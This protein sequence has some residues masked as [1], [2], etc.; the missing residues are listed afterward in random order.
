ME[1]KNVQ[2]ETNTKGLDLVDI[3]TSLTEQL[4]LSID[5]GRSEQ[6]NYFW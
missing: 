3:F 1:L 4:C 5:A 6:L 2:H